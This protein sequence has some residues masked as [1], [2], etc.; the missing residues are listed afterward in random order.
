MTEGGGRDGSNEEH[1]LIHGTTHAASIFRATKSEF[2]CIDDFSTSIPVA[3]RASTQLQPFSRDPIYHLY[4]MCSSFP[5]LTSASTAYNTFVSYFPMAT[6]RKIQKQ[7][8][9]S[10]AN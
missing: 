5:P 8:V 10:P 4:G 6:A 7:L 2:I 9:K 3:A 1:G